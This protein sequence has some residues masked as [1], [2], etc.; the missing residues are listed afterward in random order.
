M[1]KFKFIILT[2]FELSLL[3]ILAGCTYVVIL[4]KNKYLKCVQCSAFFILPCWW[5]RSEWAYSDGTCFITIE[6]NQVWTCQMMQFRYWT[7][8]NLFWY[9][10]SSSWM[11]SLAEWIYSYQLSL[12]STIL[13][14]ILILFLY[15]SSDSLKYETL[16]FLNYGMKLAQL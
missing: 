11:L 4:K 2:G 7:R 15:S 16:C 13:P 3:S 14:L 5:L 6:K 10:A 8:L 12:T 1:W 9:K